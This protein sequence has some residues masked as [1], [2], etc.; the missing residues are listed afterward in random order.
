M[1]VA[2]WPEQQARRRVSTR[3][4]SIA[5]ASKRMGCWETI[6][7][8]LVQLGFLDGD[9]CGGRVTAV[10][11]P[12]NATRA[13]LA[14]QFYNDP[15]RCDTLEDFERYK[16]IAARLLQRPTP[17]IP[18]SIVDD[19]FRYLETNEQEPTLPLLRA[20]IGGQEA[21]TRSIYHEEMA[22]RGLKGQEFTT[23]NFGCK[24]NENHEPAVLARLRPALRT[25]PGTYLDPQLGS[26]AKRPHRSIF[27]RLALIDNDHL[28]QSMVILT[29]W[30][31][32][33][34]LPEVQIKDTLTRM[35][36]ISSVAGKRDLRDPLTLRNCLEEVLGPDW[37]TTRD[38][39]YAR[40]YTVNRYFWAADK[41]EAFLNDV[42]RTVST[43][44]LEAYRF[45]LPLSHAELRK[46][47]ADALSRLRDVYG[48][49]RQ[50]RIKRILDNPAEFELVARL[51]VEEHEA[52][53]RATDSEIDK[54]LAAGAPLAEPL[55]F[56]VVY[57]TRLIN[58]GFKR[59]VQTLHLELWTW[60][61]VFR[62]V[63]RARKNNP[64][65]HGAWGRERSIRTSGR[66]A[67]AVRYV[68]LTPEHPGGPVQLPVVAEVALGRLLETCPMVSAPEM[69]KQKEARERLGFH[70][71]RWRKNFCLPSFRPAE[72]LI[73]RGAS[74]LLDLTFLPIREMTIGLLMAETAG[75]VMLDSSARWFEASQLQLDRK[76]IRESFDERLNQTS[77]SFDAV[78]KGEH[79][80]KEFHLSEP[81]MRQILHLCEMISEHRY[82][83]GEIPVTQPSAQ[84]TSKQLPAGPH[85]FHAGDS[86]LMHDALSLLFLLLYLGWDVVKA[87]DHRHLF[88]SLAKRG[89]M[90]RDERMRIMNHAREDTNNL[91]GRDTPAQA[92]AQDAFHSAFMLQ[93]EAQL[94]RLL[95]TADAPKIQALEK[96][97]RLQTKIL[98]FHSGEFDLEGIEQTQEKLRSLSIELA[99]TRLSTALPDG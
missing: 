5:S 49:N 8:S 47:I 88:N 81:T 59:I 71:A 10:R 93:R 25:I 7:S 14:E 65:A 95:A 45:V 24:R 76:R 98:E 13:S 38:V 58:D 69:L 22:S 55:Q 96:E 74:R 64:R 85:V 48:G 91:Y 20:L 26:L 75:R 15:G 50:A 1:Q 17:R 97:I 67:F 39:G 28:F 52:I 3:S 36:R 11:I 99:E 33:Q 89:G 82:E 86:V 32:Q 72:A 90:P 80:P 23:R 37:T 9:I 4:E 42:Q 92:A 27:K 66:G 34:G 19:A 70:L 44:S 41:F 61:M 29:L 12:R 73:A 78:P 60:R 51:R 79:L 54:V 18:Q 94:T 53:L 6:I 46:N 40:L 63:Y 57:E 2:P 35:A 77:W 83:G 43:D 21:L 56:S 84:H 31:I 87:H 62:Q 30:W 16:L 68:A